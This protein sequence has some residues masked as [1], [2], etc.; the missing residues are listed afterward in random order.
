MSDSKGGQ[1]AQNPQ[2]P[3][4]DEGEDQAGPLIEGIPDQDVGRSTPGD[5]GVVQDGSLRLDEGEED[6]DGRQDR[7]AQGL[8]PFREP[9]VHGQ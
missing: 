8:C 5:D 6:E 7:Q 3:D 2:E 1:D 4:K 9:E